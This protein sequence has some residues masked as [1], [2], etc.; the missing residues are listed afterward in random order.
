[1]LK[2]SDSW[3]FKV[4]FLSHIDGHLEQGSKKDG[5]D[6]DLNKTVKC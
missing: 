3:S 4:Y 2:I 6:K 1:M 5:N